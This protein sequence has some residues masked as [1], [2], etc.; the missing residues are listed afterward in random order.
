MSH[1]LVI[2][3]PRPDS[4]EPGCA[5]SGGQCFATLEVVGSG[6][7]RRIAWA[8][9]RRAPDWSDASPS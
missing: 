6:S 5:A 3:D 9:G 7:G 4:A 1:K 2:C 8:G